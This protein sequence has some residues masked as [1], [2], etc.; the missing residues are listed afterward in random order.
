[1]N[2]PGRETPLARLQASR[3]RIQRELARLERKITRAS[4]QVFAVQERIACLTPNHRRA[5]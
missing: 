4:R 3:K 1:M 2:S 5:A